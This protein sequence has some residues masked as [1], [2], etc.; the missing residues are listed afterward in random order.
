MVSL[1]TLLWPVH[2]WEKNIVLQR[3]T[4]IHSHQKKIDL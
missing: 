3:I 4:V 1:N 2:I